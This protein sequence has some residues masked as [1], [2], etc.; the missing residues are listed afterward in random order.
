MKIVTYDESS[1]IFPRNTFERNQNEQ[2]WA[3]ILPIGCAFD[4]VFHNAAMYPGF[5]PPTPSY[6]INFYNK[7][8][9]VKTITGQKTAE[10]I[11]VSNIIADVVF[12]TI[13]IIPQRRN[14]KMVIP[15]R[16]ITDFEHD[17]KRLD[18]YQLGTEN[19]LFKCYEYT[20]FY[21]TSE[22]ANEREIFTTS[23]RVIIP[24]TQQAFTK[25][26]VVFGGV[27]GMHISEAEA[28]NNKIGLSDYIMIDGGIFQIDT[29]PKLTQLS[30][31]RVNVVIVG[32]FTTER[33]ILQ[34]FT[35]DIPEEGYTMPVEAGTTILF[36]ENA[37]I[38]VTDY[39]S[40]VVTELVISDNIGG[41]YRYF[42]VML[43]NGILYHFRQQRSG[44]YIPPAP[45][46]PAIFD[47]LNRIKRINYGITLTPKV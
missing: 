13:E 31:N 23:D 34:E 18:F 35:I 37:S 14:D 17:L 45:E 41:K 21:K 32:Y 42:S 7:N 10:K 20:N 33:N 9:P 4:I 12:D 47:F 40:I 6:I 11:K 24:T 15:V 28:L 22:L 29:P 16:V 38:V 36:G 25:Y 46:E 19:A 30:S 27:S 26:N 44:S 8:L 43:S 1:V 5:E 2:C 3:S 39:D